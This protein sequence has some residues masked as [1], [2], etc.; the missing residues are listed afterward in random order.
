MNVNNFRSNDNKLRYAYMLTPQG[1]GE[2]ARLTE[3]FLRCKVSEYYEIQVK[4][5]KVLAEV[6]FDMSEPFLSDE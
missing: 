6:D 4:I 1:L 3:S 2:K 5:S